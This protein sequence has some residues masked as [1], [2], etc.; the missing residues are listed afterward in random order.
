VVDF[1]TLNKKDNI[2][3]IRTCYITYILIINLMKG[4][5]M[6]TIN[7]VD[8]MANV[9]VTGI[10]M[11][12]W[13]V[14]PD[15][16]LKAFQLW[17]RIN[18]KEGKDTSVYVKDIY[19]EGVMRGI[20]MITRMFRH[21]PYGVLPVKLCAKRSHKKGKMGY[22]LAFRTPLRYDVSPIPVA[23]VGIAGCDIHRD[24]ETNKHTEYV[25]DVSEDYTTI[26]VEGSCEK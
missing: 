10:E 1:T 13:K 25:I 6:Y 4:V 22:Q 19:E 8:D 9:G 3:P 15:E 26:Y 20:V 18:N 5:K 17:E 24:M 2:S 11:K 7:N 16:M 23:P 14:S 12:Q 21:T